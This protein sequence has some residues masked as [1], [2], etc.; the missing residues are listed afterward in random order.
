MEWMRCARELNGSGKV[1]L[2]DQALET[3]DEG[4]KVTTIEGIKSTFRKEGRKFRLHCAPSSLLHK[5][6]IKRV[7]CVLVSSSESEL[8]L[9]LLS[10][11]QH[12]D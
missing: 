9:A 10:V 2:Q 6:T 12:C 7:L 8:R 3:T 4:T 11:A 1:Q 5:V